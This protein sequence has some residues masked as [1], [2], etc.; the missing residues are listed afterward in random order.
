[1]ENQTEN[2]VS[3]QTIAAFSFHLGVMMGKVLDQ[4]E[5]MTKW[6]ADRGVGSHVYSEFLNGAKKLTTAFY[7]D[8]TKAA[9]KAETERENT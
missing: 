3:E 2:K 7:F 4:D 1:M 5:G 9:I 6:F 8:E